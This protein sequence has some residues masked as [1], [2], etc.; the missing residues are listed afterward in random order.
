MSANENA[1]VPAALASRITHLELLFKNLPPSLSLD[2]PD[3]VTTYHFY[4]NSED[5]ENEGLYY[6]FN[7]RLEICF[8]T[9]LLQG[10]PITLQERGKRLQNLIQMFKKVA[11]E[12]L[13]EQDMLQKCWLERLISVAKAAR[14]IITSKRKISDSDDENVPQTSKLPRKLKPAEHEAVRHHATALKPKLKRRDIPIVID[15]D[16]EEDNTPE[17]LELSE[18]V[19]PRST[20]LPLQPAQPAKPLRQAT[21]FSLGAKKITKEEASAQRKKIVQDWRQTAEDTQ[22]KE[23]RDLAKREERKRALNRDRQ[24]RHQDRKKSSRSG[25]AGNV[26]KDLVLSRPQSHVEHPD[27]SE[28]SR[29]EGTE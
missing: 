9:H 29:P 28:I 15:S 1:G 14:A 7:R 6:A 11:K 3:N 8:Q 17:C 25:G 26:M 16:S 4:F 2:L 12:V 13:Q 20:P 5:V 21:L 27:L 18:D 24:Q 23:A 22:A 10:R 19:L